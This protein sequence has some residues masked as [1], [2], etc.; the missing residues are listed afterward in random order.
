MA[1]RIANQ[2]K[3][4]QVQIIITTS[5]LTEEEVGAPTDGLDENWSNHDDEEVPVSLLVSV[6]LI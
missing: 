2:F 4:A 3:L 1:L 5:S 6:F